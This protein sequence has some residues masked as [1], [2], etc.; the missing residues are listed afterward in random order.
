M[1]FSLI[2][3]MLHVTVTHAI[4]TETNLLALFSESVQWNS[5]PHFS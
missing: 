2:T 1:H 5:H 4:N 3:Q